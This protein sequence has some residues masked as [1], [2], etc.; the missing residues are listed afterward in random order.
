MAFTKTNTR[1]ELLDDD[2]GQGRPVVLIRGWPRDA[3]AWFIAP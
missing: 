3:G 2:R 1:T